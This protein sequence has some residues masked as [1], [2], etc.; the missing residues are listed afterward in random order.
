MKVES[1]T[2]PIDKCTNL[3]S[4]PEVSSNLPLTQ[5]GGLEQI[6][7]LKTDAP[8]VITSNHPQSKYK[9]DGIVNGAS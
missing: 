6:I 1:C 5:T 2:L 8:I 4:P 9:E 3:E 7:L